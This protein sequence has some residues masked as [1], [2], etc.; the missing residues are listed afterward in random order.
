MRYENVALLCWENNKPKT[1]LDWSID[2][3]GIVTKEG[4]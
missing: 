4:G 1:S 2:L 3:V